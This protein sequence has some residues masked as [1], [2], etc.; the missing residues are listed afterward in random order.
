MATSKRKKKRIITVDMT[1]VE[2]RTLIPEGDYKVRVNE[3]T[4]E[5]GEDSGKPYLNWTLEVVGG[6]HDGKTL[7]H[8]T[9]L[10]PQALFN[11]KSTLISM[12][13]PVPEKTIDIDL[14]KLVDGEFGVS[15][16]HDVYD[17]KKKSKVQE[18]FPLSDD[19]D[20]DTDDDD[21]NDEDDWVDLEEMDLSELKA[22]AKENDIDLSELSKTD[23]K[24]AKKV[25]DFIAAALEEEDDGEDDE[26]DDEDDEDEGGDEIDYSEMTKADLKAECRERGIKVKKEDKKPDL[27]RKLEK[28]D[29]K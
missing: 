2:T 6:E 7:Y 22:F 24:K 3:V 16:Y 17:G 14:D 15:V 25:R 18:V 26:D 20:I 13:L 29:E 27:I 23:K 1:D 21:T 19:E 12:G 5:V 9:S 28:D 11:L 10:Q 8:T 4:E